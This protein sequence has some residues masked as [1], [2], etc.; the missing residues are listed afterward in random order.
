MI[1]RARERWSAALGHATSIALVLVGC[2]GIIEAL[3]RWHGHWI[4]R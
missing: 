3:A 4:G 1:A 2:I